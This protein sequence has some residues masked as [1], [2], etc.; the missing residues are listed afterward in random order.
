MSKGLAPLR[1]SILKLMGRSPAH[2][3]YALDMAARGEEAWEPTP[4]MRLGS[5]AHKVFL[6]QPLPV[7][8]PG[9]VRRGKEWEAFKSA[10]ADKEIVKQSELDAVVEIA[11]ALQAH[12]EARDLLT[13]TIEQTVLFDLGGRNCRATPDVFV[14]GAHLTDLKT[15]R[16]ANPQW[17]PYQALKL[18]YHGQLSFYRDGLERAGFAPPKELRIVAIETAPPYAV[19]VFGV[20]PRA[21]DFGRRTYRAWFEQF[22]VCEASDDWP[23]YGPGVLDAPEEAVELTGFDEDES[24]EPPVTDGNGLDQGEL[25]LI[26]L[27]PKAAPGIMPS[28]LP[29]AES[30]K[31][32]ELRAYLK[33]QALELATAETLQPFREEEK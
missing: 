31:L 29:R 6:K 11:T 10:N 2:A 24:D 25:P 3:R 30:D 26:G 23:G 18:G 4:S 7:V 5:L 12:A 14:P 9:P 22:L 19:C 20:T 27:P 21:E 16:D 28:S 13:G 17:F 32:A 15:T 8:Y 1:Y 33:R